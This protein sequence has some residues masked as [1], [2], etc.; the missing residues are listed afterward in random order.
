MRLR[1]FTIAAF[2]SLLAAGAMLLLWH[3]SYRVGDSSRLAYFT[4]YPDCDLVHE[5]YAKSSAGGLSVSHHINH[6]ARGE[7]V[8][9]RGASI[10]T[11]ASP[12]YPFFGTRSLIPA[13]NHLTIWQ[14]AGF[15]LGNESEGTP[16]SVVRGIILPD[17][18]CTLLLLLLPA[19]WLRFGLPVIRRRRRIAA[20]LCGQCG[21]DLRATAERC[22]ECGALVRS[23]VA[24]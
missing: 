22:P 12:M 4:A 17:W 16:P 15:E 5:W 6:F 1:L 7:G 21:Y 10:S 13:R 23:A 24:A 3:R 8:K 9:L 2:L 18:F 19:L 14:R 20:G 11:F